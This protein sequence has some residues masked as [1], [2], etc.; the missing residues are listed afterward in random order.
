MLGYISENIL[1]GLL[2]TAQWNQIEEYRE[3]GF[4]LLDVR[5]PSEFAA[6]SIPGARSM[7][8]DEI[9]NRVTEL[10]NR[11][12]LV[13]CQVGQRGHTASMLLKELGFSA[14]N[15]DGGYHLWSNSPAKTELE[16][17]GV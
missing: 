3:K 17:A 4:E 6:G 2:E 12:I 1:S 16:K 9:R 11:N 5:T 10:K 13:I 7:P 8:V 14:V 15:L